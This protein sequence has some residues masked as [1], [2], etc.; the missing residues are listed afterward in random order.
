MLFVAKCVSLADGP[1]KAAAPPAGGEPESG[2]P[3]GHEGA[4]TLACSGGEPPTQGP[5]QRT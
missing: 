5:A 2:G 3:G 1:P 4:P